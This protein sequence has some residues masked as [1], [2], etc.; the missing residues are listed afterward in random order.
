M[1]RGM[2]GPRR[3]DGD[4]AARIWDL[5]VNRAGFRP[6]VSA[7]SRVSASSLACGKTAVFG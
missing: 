6:Q 2:S 4:K 7:G 3:F 5:V 1:A